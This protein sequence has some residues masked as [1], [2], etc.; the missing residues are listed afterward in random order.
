MNYEKANLNNY[1]V[2]LKPIVSFENWFGFSNLPVKATFDFSEI[3]D[4]YHQ[5]LLQALL[6]QYNKSSGS[7]CSSDSQK[8]YIGQVFEFISKV[9]KRN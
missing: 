6:N 7:C 1:Y 2:T 8:G 5:A 9:F 4:A 3:P